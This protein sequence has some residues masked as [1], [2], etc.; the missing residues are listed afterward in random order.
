MRTEP[1][2][3]AAE[4]W[5]TPE[6]P[7]AMGWVPGGQ[8][9]HVGG[10]WYEALLRAEQVAWDGERKYQGGARVSGPS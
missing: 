10:C 8:T 1:T 9:E 7:E 5:P 4:D 6:H 2:H 3:L